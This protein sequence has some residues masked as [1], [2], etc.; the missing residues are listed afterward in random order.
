MKERSPQ[1]RHLIGCC[2][3]R[4]WSRTQHFDKRALEIS[5]VEERP[6]LIWIWEARSMK[7][8]MKK[9][10]KRLHHPKRK[11]WCHRKI[12]NTSSRKHSDCINQNQFLFPILNH[13]TSLTWKKRKEKVLWRKICFKTAS[14]LDSW[15]WK[16]KR[17][18]LLTRWSLWF[19]RTTRWGWCAQAMT[20]N[21]KR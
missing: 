9:K 15:L 8:A 16:K 18:L 21:V 7:S 4:P 10:A 5:K 6:L 20:T 12:W 13:C 11:E 1:I 17:T 19:A 2:R 3:S 14:S